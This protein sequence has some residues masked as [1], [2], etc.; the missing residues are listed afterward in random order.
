MVVV[1][2][3]TAALVSALVACAVTTRTSSSVFPGSSVLPGFATGASLWRLVGWFLAHTLQ[4][5]RD[6]HSL[7]R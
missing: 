3:W 2:L 4:D 7:L 6:L 5:R 1:W